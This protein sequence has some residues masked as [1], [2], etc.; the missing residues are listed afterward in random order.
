MRD[1]GEFRV[2][3]RNVRTAHKMTLDM[4]GYYYSN[5]SVVCVQPTELFPIYMYILTLL[6][7]FFAWQIWKI[8]TIDN[9]IS[10]SL[11][12]GKNFVVS[13]IVSR[14]PSSFVLEIESLML[15]IDLPGNICLGY[16]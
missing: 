6:S 4:T 1:C 9:L 15:W 13:T 5:N 12:V 2:L 16:V 3:L 7:S 10:G 14:T 11:V 8:G